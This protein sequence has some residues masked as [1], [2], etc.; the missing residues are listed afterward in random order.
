MSPRFVAGMFVGLE[1]GAKGWKIRLPNRT[2]VTSLRGEVP[3]E[4][5]WG[6]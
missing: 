2:T 3:G 1:Q 6:H 4:A 5:A